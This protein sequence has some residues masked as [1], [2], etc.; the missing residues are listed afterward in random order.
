M[1]AKKERMTQKQYIKTPPNARINLQR[2]TITLCAA[3]QTGK[4]TGKDP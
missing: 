4:T 3:T 2:L 1:K